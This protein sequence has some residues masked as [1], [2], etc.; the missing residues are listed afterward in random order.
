MRLLLAVLLVIYLAPVKLG[1]AFAWKEGQGLKAAAGVMVWGVR[2]QTVRRLGRGV[3][4]APDEKN[5]PMS[6]EAVRTVKEAVRHSERA[7]RYFFLTARTEAMNVDALIAV[8]DAA[9]CALAQGVLDMIAGAV[10][11]I[12]PAFHPR[13]RGQLTGESQIRGRCIVSIRLGNLLIVMLLG[14]LGWAQGSLKRKEEKT[15]S[16]IPSKN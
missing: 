16:I 12:Y 2:Y 3:P 7:R 10:K 11:H 5:L 9:V 15:W 1:A 13:I 8:Q 4:D 6:T 14:V